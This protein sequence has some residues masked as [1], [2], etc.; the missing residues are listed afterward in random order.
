MERLEGL[1]RPLEGGAAG[2]ADHSARDEHKDSEPQKALLSSEAE[3]NNDHLNGNGHDGHVGQAVILS[4]P[5]LSY[6]QR[7]ADFILMPVL[8]L[9]WCGLLVSTLNRD[10]IL[11]AWGMPLL[12]IGSA[13]LANAV[14]VGG[15][16]VFVPILHLLGYEMKLG[17][18]FA[19][20]TMT[21]GNGIFGMLNWLRKD[22]SAIAFYAIPSAVIPAW[23]GSAIGTLRPFMTAEHCKTLFALF[24]IKAAAVVWRGLYVSRRNLRLGKPFTVG[25]GSDD[26][27]T[28]AEL[29]RRKNSTR[30]IASVCSFLAGWILVAH[31]GIGNALV[32]FLVF[33]FVF[34]LTPKEAVVT[35][36]VCGGFTSFCPFLIHLFILKDVPLD[37]WVMGLPGVYL[38]AKIAPKIH[39][40]IGIGNIL[41][42]FVIFLLLVAVLM[43][44]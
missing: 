15:G 7:H 11:S 16:I 24:A 26:N 25:F 33:T 42:A 20:A 17:A 5:I 23:I 2:A 32:S 3:R 8:P 22:P 38:G 12:G 21:F 13:T 30:Y 28:A 14:P 19:V 29:A 4:H 43:V 40:A 27:Q 34:R 37:L 18:A 36:I 31:I 35:A 1:S 41:A 10:D 39:E 6:L 9:L 44:S